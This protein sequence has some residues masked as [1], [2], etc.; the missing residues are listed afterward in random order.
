MANRSLSQLSI[1]TEKEYNLRVKREKELLSKEIEE[2]YRGELAS[3]SQT[4]NLLELEKKQA[5]ELEERVKEEE[6]KYPKK[7]EKIKNKAKKG[8]K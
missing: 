8:K 1:I 6:S 4:A 3:F 7:E 5:K 2:K